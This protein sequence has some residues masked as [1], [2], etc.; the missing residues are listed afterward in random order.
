MAKKVMRDFHL[1]AKKSRVTHTHTH[2]LIRVDNMSLGRKHR[3]VSASA[4]A[5]LCSC[6]AF[7]PVPA[8]YT[9][10]HTNTHLRKGRLTNGISICFPLSARR[11]KRADIGPLP[12]FHQVVTFSTL[13]SFIKGGTS[14][15]WLR[16]PRCSLL[17]APA[18]CRHPS[19]PRAADGTPP[20]LTQQSRPVQNVHF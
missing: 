10:T 16:Q 17:P 6:A 14:P 19:R 7:P 1:V 8:A 3:P 9:H 5:D 13:D 18:A 20:P 12:R 2:T 15:E 11:R 4:A